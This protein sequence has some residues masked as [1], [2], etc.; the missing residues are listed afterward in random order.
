MTQRLTTVVERLLLFSAF[1]FL[2][3]TSWAQNCPDSI[4]LTII[5]VNVAK[6]DEICIDMAVDNFE[7]IETLQ[8]SLGWNPTVLEFVRVEPINLR[9]LR[10]SNFGDRD[11]DKGL[12]RFTWYDEDG[13]NGE[14]LADGTVI[15]RLCFKAVGEPG[16]STAIVISDIPL[17]FEASNV[18]GD[19]L[20]LKNNNANNLINITLPSMLCVI[21]NSC[22]TE[23]NS[24]TAKIT[25]WGGQRPYTYSGIGQNGVLNNQGEMVVWNGLSPGTYSVTVTDNTGADTTLTIEIVDAPPIILDSVL[26][27]N[28]SCDGSTPGVLEID[29]SGGAAPYSIAWSP[30]NQYNVT[31]VTGLNEGNYRVTVKDSFGC[32]AVRDFELVAGDVDVDIDVIQNASCVGV[33]NGQIRVTVNGGTT[34]YEFSSSGTTYFPFPGNEITLRNLAAGQ[35]RILIRDAQG[36]VRNIS[37]TIPV[38]KELTAMGTTT[39]VLC[40]DEVNGTIRIEGRTNG[41]PLGP[42]GFLLEDQNNNLIIGGINQGTSYSSP[43][44]RAGTYF[45]TLSD[46]DGCIF[47]DTFIINQP[48]PISSLVV[49]QD[50]IESC[51]PG[52]DAF[53][54]VTGTGGNGQPYFYRWLNTG[55]TTARIDGLSAG[56]YSVEVRDSNGCRDTVDYAV[57]PAEAPQITGFDSVS[58]SCTGS[59]DGS[60][61][62]RFSQGSGAVN[63]YQW[64]NGSNTATINNLGP[65]NYCVTITDTNGCSTSACADLDNPANSIVIDSIVIDEPECFGYKGTI[66]VFASG[67]QA[68]YTYSWSTGDVFTNRPVYAGLD[69]GT[70]TVTV[71]DAGN[72]GE[73]VQTVELTQPAQ[74]GLSPI[75]LDSA[76]CHGLCDG[77]ATIQLSGGPNAAAGYTVIWSNG[78]TYPVF[79]GQPAVSVNLCPGRNFIVAINENCGSD[80]LFFDIAEPEEIRLDI[81]NSA[82]NMPSCFGRADGSVT[83][84]AM[85]GRGGNYNYVWVP[86]G[87]LGPTLNNIGKDTLYVRIT[88]GRGCSNI[89]SIFINEP[90][91][92]TVSVLPS[93]TTDVTCNGST[94]GR[95][96]VDWN[97]GNPGPASYSWSPNVS[98]DSVATGLA[99]GIYQVTVTDSRGCSNILIHEVLEPAPLVPD[100]PSPEPIACTGDRTEIVVLDVTGGTGPYYYTINNGSRIDIGDGLDVLAGTYTLR[101]FDRQGCSKDTIIVIDQPGELRA[102]IAQAPEVRVNLGEMIQLN[103]SAQGSSRI[104]A[105]EWAPPTN[106]SDPDSLITKVMPDR[107]ETYTMTVFDEN[108]CEASATVRVIVEALRKVFIPNAFTPNDDGLNDVFWVSTGFGVVSIESFEI[109]NRWGDLVYRISSP[110]PAD[111]NSGLGWDGSFG[112]KLLEPGVFAYRINVRFADDAIITYQGDVTLIR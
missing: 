111:N 23:G 40:F 81:A 19:D 2:F 87:I 55:A 112:G 98:A 57:T 11:A 110:V 4:G 85:G 92:I 62:V 26:Q 20:C 104:I 21:A 41:T 103:G 9:Y 44:L 18:F 67:G 56:V 34:P 46:N 80:T 83:V 38:S 100:I 106:L 58:I 17:A 48:P 69:A 102:S 53:L 68:P 96:T 52:S 77:R 39:D 84:S 22:S 14:T 15:F 78:E 101:V 74:I 37:Y 33:N 8:F 54:E 27:I 76:S 64:S 95:I 71:T 105:V 5:P 89:D 42:Y 97:G 1:L 66:T 12:L 63:S 94:D 47:Q 61:T 75:T 59:T 32:T 60:L 107:T 50:S 29:I 10:V 99:P 43:G 90:D 70:Y 25:V 36:C 82:I 3:N 88:D 45:F 65:G 6:G 51:V 109:F 86:S 79:N 24:G 28:P 91:S 73:I 7:G 30:V 72:C 49:S 93:A 16:D 31:R 35:G 13:I 108:G